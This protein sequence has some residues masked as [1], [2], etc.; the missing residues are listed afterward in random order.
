MCRVNT[1]T[2]YSTVPCVPSYMREHLLLELSPSFFPS[3]LPPPPP[4]PSFQYLPRLSPRVPHLC[5]SEPPYICTRYGGCV[6][7]LSSPACL[8]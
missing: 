5:T 2:Q 6:M 1:Y 7:Y 8:H 4:P 3:T